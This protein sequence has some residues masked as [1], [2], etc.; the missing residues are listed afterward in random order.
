MFNGLKEM[1]KRVGPAALKPSG[2]KKATGR[3]WVYHK[4]TQ[5]LLSAVS[6]PAG[7]DKTGFIS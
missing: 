4:R 5:G 7:V 3:I 1:I 2:S 6:C